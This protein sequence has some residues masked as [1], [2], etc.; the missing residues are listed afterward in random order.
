VFCVFLYVAFCFVS[1]SQEITTEKLLS[2]QNGLFVSSG[3]LNDQLKPSQERWSFTCHVVVKVVLSGGLDTDG[4]GTAQCPC[5]CHKKLS[6]NS[7]TNSS[8]SMSLKHCQS[9]ALKVTS[10]MSFTSFS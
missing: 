5:V 7:S 9:C 8:R 3:I 2:L 1:T 6:T 4:F 10:I